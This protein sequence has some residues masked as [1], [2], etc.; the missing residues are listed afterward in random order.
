MSG[1]T[2]LLIVLMSFGFA[3]GVFCVCSMWGELR[4]DENRG[5]VAVIT[6]L[7]FAFLGIVVWG[8][9]GF[10]HFLGTLWG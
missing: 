3:F 6:P 1:P 7:L 4:G 2:I 9:I 8:L 10:L 5:W